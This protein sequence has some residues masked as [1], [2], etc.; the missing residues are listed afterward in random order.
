METI[1]YT[2][3][4]KLDI[5]VGTITHAEAVPKS[6]KLLKLE[7][8]FGSEGKRQI[9]AGIASMVPYLLDNDPANLAGY[10]V[11]AVLNLAP[12]KLMG[13]ESHG[14]ILAAHGKDDRICPVQCPNAPDGAQLG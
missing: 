12:R 13:I 7:V 6:T 8:D 5:R 9:V 3:F 1:E 10:Q 4:A 14:M 11:C 2:D